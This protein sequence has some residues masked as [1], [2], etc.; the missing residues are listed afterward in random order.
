ML[1]KYFILVGTACKRVT[2]SDGDTFHW[3]RAASLWRETASIKHHNGVPYVLHDDAV[4]LF[5]HSF[6][7]FLPSFPE[8][9]T[10]KVLYHNDT[11]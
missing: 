5:S 1:P 2:E 10:K 3:F 6:S 7:F 8:I 9:E 11:Y 4:P